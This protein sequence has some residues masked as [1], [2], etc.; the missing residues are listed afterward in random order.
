MYTQLHCG[1][2][3]S[4]SVYLTINPS[5]HNRFLNNFSIVLIMNKGYMHS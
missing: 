1:T 3:K 2:E 4:G 5:N